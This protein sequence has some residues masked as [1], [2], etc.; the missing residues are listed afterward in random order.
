MR[1]VIQCCELVQQKTA[2]QSLPAAFK[3]SSYLARR[4]LGGDPQ[5]VAE[6]DEYSAAYNEVDL[7]DQLKTEH[8]EN[9]VQGEASTGLL[10]V[11]DERFNHLCS[12]V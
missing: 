1:G 2:I 6:C 3:P 10:P 4:G 9:N 8:G 5:S 11:D 7:N 12:E